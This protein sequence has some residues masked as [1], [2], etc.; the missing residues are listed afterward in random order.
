LAEGTPD[1]LSKTATMSLRLGFRRALYGLAAL[2]LVPVAGAAAVAP[3]VAAAAKAE[4]TVVWYSALEAPALNMMVE[5]FNASHPGIVV[6]G[7]QIA[8][9]RIPPRV[10]TE[11]SAGKVLGDVI[12]GDQLSVSQLGET[13]LLQPFTVTDPEKFVKGSIDP[14]GMWAA[15]FSETTVIAWN[16]QKLKADGLRP[17]T[18]LADLGRPEWRGKI[19]LDNAAFNWY[20]AVLLTQKDAAATLKR[21]ADNHPLMTSGHTVTVTQLQNGEF[22]VTPTAYGYM[23]DQRHAAGQ[24]VDF[25]N[26]TPNLVN[27][28]PVAILKGAPHP[29]AARVLVDW[30]LSPEG[31]TLIAGTGHTSRRLDVAN[32]LR[33]FDPRKPSYVMPAPD[34]TQYNALVS[35]YKALFGIGG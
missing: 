32:N 28:E 18:S 6:Q 12:N 24:P 17:P 26:L 1:A 5:K 30:L 15:V 4:G 10:L 8:S 19:G 3:S 9:T 27:L 25:L 20:Q 35:G 2:A 29:N 14:K 21:I 16:P 22:D 23:A 34:R 11:E 31:Q 13:N 33:V 7:L